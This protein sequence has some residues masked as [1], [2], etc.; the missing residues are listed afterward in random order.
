MSYLTS[1]LL[2]KHDRSGFNSGVP[3]L[4]AYIRTQV[5]Q[6]IKKR[7]AACF[8][9]ANDK[10]LVTGFYTLSSASISIEEAPDEIKNKLPKAYK[11]LPAILL[12]RLAVDQKL[13]GTGIGKLLL[14]DA[15]KRCF[16][17]TAILGSWALIVDPIDE[18]ARSFYNK[19]GFVLLST[20]RMFLPMKTI[21]SLFR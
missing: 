14:M 20:G 17:L 3:S 16:E 11:H 19:Y 8:V 1:P 6:D 9:T 13:Q 4:D 5:N 21:E 18:H 2:A 12:G 15:M 10:G 7:L